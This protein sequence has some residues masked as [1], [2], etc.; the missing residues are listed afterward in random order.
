LFVALLSAI[1]ATKSPKK[2]SQWAA[3]LGSVNKKMPTAIGKRKKNGKSKNK[4]V[5]ENSINDLINAEK[6]TEKENRNANLPEDEQKRIEKM[7]EEG[8]KRQYP[9]VSDTKAWARTLKDHFPTEHKAIDEFVRVMKEYGKGFDDC[10]GLVKLLPLPL[11]KF[12]I[13]I[14]FF[15]LIN[16]KWANSGSETTKDVIERYGHKSKHSGAN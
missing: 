12:L 7:E 14:R 5:D 1:S 3:S 11:A 8:K 6:T 4:V 10:C 2:V 9:M 13:K 16:K 15:D